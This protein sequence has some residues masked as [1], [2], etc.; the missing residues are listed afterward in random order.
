[1]GCPNLPDSLKTPSEDR[2]VVFV[3]T[4]NGGAF[5]R[6]ITSNELVPIKVSDLEELHGS[7]FLE[8]VE[9]GHS[10]HDQSSLIA[11]QLNI[12]QAPIRMDS[13]C[14]YGCLSR[15]DAEIYLRLPVRDDY[16]ENIWVCYPHAIV[17][18]RAYPFYKRTTL[19][20]ICL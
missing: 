13:Q 9:S 5:K 3:A 8:S 15:G 10:S 14:K 20:D 1:M 19:Q 4:K 18:T 11:R 17:K 12:T 6:A 7:A 16:E 2:G